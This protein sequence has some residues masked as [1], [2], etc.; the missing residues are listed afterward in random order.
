MILYRDFRVFIFCFDEFVYEVNKINFK[1]LIIRVGFWD[2][3]I[4]SFF[5]VWV[6][7]FLRIK[8]VELVDGRINEFCIID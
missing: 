8:L 5:F 2:Y 4:N 7:F 1:F 6:V 3:L